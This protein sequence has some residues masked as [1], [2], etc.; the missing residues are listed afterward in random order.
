MKKFHSQG[1]FYRTHSQNDES[2]K[3]GILDINAKETSKIYS[4]MSLTL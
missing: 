1:I 4:N 3:T 2:Q